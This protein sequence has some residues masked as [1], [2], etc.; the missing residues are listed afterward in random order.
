MD[1]ELR[2]VAS[3][4]RS[5]RSSTRACWSR[6][7]GSRRTAR[8]AAPACPTTSWPRATRRSSTRRSTSASR[9][10]PARCAGTAPP[11]GLDDHAV[12]AGLQHRRRRRTP[13]STY[14]VAR[15]DGDETLVVAEPLLEQALGEGWTVQRP[16]H[17]ARTWS[18]GP[19]SARS[20]WSTVPRASR[21][22]SW[23]SPT[24][25][26]P[27]TAP[28]W[29]TSPPR[30][31]PT[32]SRSAAR[33]GLPVVN[34]VGPTGTSSDDVPLVGGA[35][36]QER[37]RRPRRRTCEAR[38]LLFRHVPLRAQLPA[39]LALPHRAALLR[40]AVLVHPHHRRSR[41]QLLARERE[42]QLVPGDDQARPLRRLAGQQ[43]RLG[44]VPQPLLGHAA[45][46]LA[47][48]AT[49]T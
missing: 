15:T 3:G 40:A 48:R 49:T 31:A 43:H 14:V 9:S 34:P 30:S 23:C 20:S 13:T 44:A 8:A 5:S 35:V 21:R 32:T 41:T 29:C 28:A 12:D 38:G 42:D 26:P 47:L 4:G 39:L 17:R 27:R 10:P 24:T 2:R 25:S 7:T 11:A 22:T 37:R 36:L 18:A 46:D 19:T 16:V 45:A 33:Y 6:T 1:P